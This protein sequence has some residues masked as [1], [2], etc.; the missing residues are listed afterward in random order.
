VN[1]HIQ[2]NI[3]GSIDTDVPIAEAKARGA[4]M[5]FGE[6][7]GDLVRV[8][9]F[10]PNY[11]IELCGGTHVGAT[12]EIGLFQF[13]SEGS[14]ASGIRRIEAVVGKSAL[15]LISGERDQL[16][17]VRHQ[18]KGL[19]R[20][21][22]EEVA[23][24]LAETKRLQKEIARYREQSLARDLD[25]FVAGAKSVADIRLVRGQYDGVAM[26]TLLSLGEELRSRVGANAISVLGSADHEAGKAYLVATVSDDLISS[27]GLKAGTLVGQIARHV[28]GG[29]G[30]RPTIAS[31][32]GKSPENLDK[33]LAAVP[34]ILQSLL[35]A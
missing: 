32:G 2:R 10:D 3:T 24:L 19:D 28:G 34:E 15:H 25:T 31:A 22:P 33:A 27:K 9:T 12:G 13:V 1:E 18:F 35:G 6:K 14:I 21:L 8:V 23:E 26:D 17:E 20:P 30:G 11:S 16:H 29:G 4:M 7:Y 5:L